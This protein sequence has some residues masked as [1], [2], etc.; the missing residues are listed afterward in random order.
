V[1]TDAIDEYYMVHDR[2]WEHATNGLDGHLC[3]G[4][5][6]RRLGRTRQASDFPAR[7]VNTTEPRA[8]GPADANCLRRGHRP[9][10]A[11]LRSPH[12]ASADERPDSHD[13]PHRR[14]GP[15]T[16]GG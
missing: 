13:E 6:E 4:C 1:D 11:P 8:W 7:P 10:A 5:L 15:L 16:A 2:V 12:K 3:I 14:L 9:A